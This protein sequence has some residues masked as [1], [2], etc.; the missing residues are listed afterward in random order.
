MPK[1]SVIIPVYNVE[2]Y[3]DRCI[4]S[5]VGQT[6][7]NIEIILVDDG[8]SDKSGSMCE[9][10]AEKDSRIRVIHK[11]NGGLSDA[12]NAGLA[13]ATGEYISFIDSDDSVSKHFLEYML[14]TIIDTNSDL[15]ECGRTDIY[16]DIEIYNEEVFSQHKIHSYDINKAMELLVDNNIIY[17]TVWDKLYKREVITGISFKKNKLH[18]DEFFTWRVI[19]QCKRVTKIEV[20]LYNYYHRD[21]SIMENGFSLARLDG[22]EA[23]MER[24][25]YIK[26]NMKELVTKSKMSVAMLCIYHMQN[27]M[28]T[29]DK[30][31]IK[32]G[33]KRLTDYYKKV[34][35]SYSEIM[36]QPLNL[37]VWISISN[38]YFPL[39]ARIRNALHK[40]S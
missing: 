18:E 23:K 10:W 33:K 12:R 28:K 38:I 32:E 37:R 31:I 25:E 26:D 27:C 16:D 15:V 35:L 19:L 24:H 14:K 30:Y 34:K 7:R 13:I 6:Y 29:G 20:P 22:I 3:L 1:I 2:M 17:Q 21:G 9:E 5:V 39:S 11:E 40:G 4:K 8:S 36:S